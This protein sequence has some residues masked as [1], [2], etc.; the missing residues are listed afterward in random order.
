MLQF[1]VYKTTSYAMLIRGPNLKTGRQGAR[2]NIVP[3]K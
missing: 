1:N 2:D 3:V